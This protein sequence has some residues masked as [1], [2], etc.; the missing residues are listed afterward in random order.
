VRKKEGIGFALFL[1][2][3]VGLLLINSFSYNFKTRLIPMSVGGVSFILGLFI[4]LGEVFPR[5]RQFF[6]VDLFGR[7]GM[8]SQEA[9]QPRWSE[10]KGLLIAV[11]WLILFA[12]LIFMVGFSLAIP[13][14]VFIFVKFFGKQSWL[15]S[16][17]VMAMVWIFIYGLFQVLMDYK[18]FEG[19]LFGGIL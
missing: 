10:K 3:I 16:F 15:L 4:L 19:V 17:M 7:D 9:Y 5:F 13:V 1:V 14:C 8:A 12:L 18:L 6:E 2:C 11:S